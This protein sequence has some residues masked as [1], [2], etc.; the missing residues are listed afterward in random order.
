MDGERGQFLAGS[1]F[2]GDEH[3]GVGVGHFADS[4]K[5]LLHRLAGAD[6]LVVAAS[7]GRRA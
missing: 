7:R 2:A 6:H 1:R 5:E 4:A 3:A